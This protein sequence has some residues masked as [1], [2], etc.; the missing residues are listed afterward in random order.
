MKLLTPAAC[1]VAAMLT[2]CG[3]DSGKGSSQKDLISPADADAVAEELLVKVNGA[4]AQSKEGDVPAP[5]ATGNEPVIADLLDKVNVEN[6]QKVVLQTN[7]DATSPL[8]L[9]FSKVTGASAY[10]EFDIATATKTQSALEIE[11][12]IPSNITD[13]EFC[14]QFSAQDDAGRT[15]APLEVCFEVESSAD[16]NLPTPAA[17]FTESFIS[18]NTFSV[19]IDGDVEEFVFNADGTGSVR[20]APN[21]DNDFDENDVNSISWSIDG[22]GRLLFTEFGS[23]GD[24]WQWILTASSIS[25]D[26]ASYAVRV[27]GDSD[28][29]SASGTMQRVNGN[30]QPT[31]TST[32]T[33]TTAPTN[34][35]APTG[36]MTPTP[37][38]APNPTPTPTSAPDP[39]VTPSP[40]ATPAPTM[41][42]QQV[43]Q[44]WQGTW[45]YACTPIQASDGT[46]E[47]ITGDW[48]IVDDTLTVTESIWRTNT[49]CS[50]A[51]D[52]SYQEFG[53]L[54]IGSQVTAADGQ[55]AFNLTVVNQTES[56]TNE[57]ILRVNDQQFQ[58]G[59]RSTLEFFEPIYMRRPAD[60]AADCFNPVLYQEGTSLELTTYLLDIDEDTGGIDTEETFSET[61]TT[62]GAT[63]FDGR[64]VTQI[65]STS[66]T[67]RYVQFD[68]TR[69]SFAFA[70]DENSAGESDR[71]RPALPIYLDLEPGDSYSVTYMEE[72]TNLNDANELET[73]VETIVLQVTYTGRETINIRAG[74]FD[75][76]RFDYTFSDGDG[77]GLVDGAPQTLSQTSYFGAQSGLEILFIESN[78]DNGDEEFRE[79]LVS[80]TI[81][82]E[83]VN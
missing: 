7:I 77:D 26:S 27:T 13:G 69:P 67:T 65:S 73:T 14:Q 23:S 58:L 41:T 32:T 19:S 3:G 2:A 40:S 78:P 81:N 38:S 76:C 80:G 56:E 17:A 64:E 29:L 59:Y 71:Y 74:T 57:F 50:G 37:T 24:Q 16:D 66:G 1:I 20:F 83:P 39:T 47:S 30:A 28:T 33:P 79:E 44:A 34:A 18:G 11:I 54:T 15:S 62:N 68:A 31:P 75:S 9:L 12:T 45:D 60:S 4:T 48:A 36:S 55:P 82:G 61:R 5:T 25:S 35:P 10:L 42:A 43:L 46:P 52:E 6:G 49:E 70:G 72:E 51:P 63:T 21:P 8:S 22:N 53:T